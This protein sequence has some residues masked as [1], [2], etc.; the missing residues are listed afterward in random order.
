MPEAGWASGPSLSEIAEHRPLAS[1][2]NSRDVLFVRI[3]DQVRC[4]EDSCPHIGLSM[5]RGEIDAAHTL[6][7]PWHGMEFNCLTGECLSSPGEHLALYPVRIENG[8]ILVK[9]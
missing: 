6:T 5:A 3:G 7:C 2:I 9:L 1:R 8:R 4:L